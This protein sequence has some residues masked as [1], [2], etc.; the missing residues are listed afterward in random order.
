MGAWQE[1]SRRAVNRSNLKMPKVTGQ[2]KSITIFEFKKEWLEYKRAAALTKQEG[3]AELKQA[4]Q[5]TQRK[6]MLDMKEE[7]EIFAHLM[8]LFGNPRLLLAQRLEEAKGW[9]KCTGTDIQ[10][11]D[12]LSH[13]KTRVESTYELAMEYN[14]VLEL[15]CMPFFEVVESKLRPEFVRKLAKCHTEHADESGF[16]SSSIKIYVL[17]SFLNEKYDQYSKSCAVNAGKLNVYSDLLSQS[18]SGSGPGKGKGGGGDQ[19]GGA[20][21]VGATHAGCGDGNILASL[22]QT[23]EMAAAAV[24]VAAE[25]AAMVAAAAVLRVRMGLTKQAAELDPHK[26][27]DPDPGRA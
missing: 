10:V 17:L 18:G 19:R 26:L 2:P 14:I 25:V 4:I 22:L 9:S 23:M 3:L 15:L 20:H 12:W 24:A 13:V 11:R 7:E 5:T 16:A 1:K 6:A 8:V 27:V 21:Q